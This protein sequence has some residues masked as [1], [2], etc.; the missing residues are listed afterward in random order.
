[1]AYSFT[2]FPVLTT[3]RLIL[4]RVRES[5]WPELLALRG[6]KNVMLY[7]PRPLV[8]TKEEAIEHFN[9]I[10]SKIEENLGINWAITRKGEDKL[11]GVLGHYRLQPENFRSEI[12]YMLLPEAHGQGIV[13]EAVTAILKYG[14]EHM[15]LHSVEA[16]ID[17]EN[18]A[19]EKV[20]QKLGFVK[21]AHILENEYFDGRFWDTVIYSMLQRNFKPLY[22]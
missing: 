16:V 15:Q 1:M 17:P 5:D 7:I 8:T 6:D 2:P 14:F 13:P 21:E 11:L 19:S 18:A 22:E 3:S 10:D 20:L 4:R 9:M 12:G